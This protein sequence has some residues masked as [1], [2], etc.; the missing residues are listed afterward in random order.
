MGRVLQERNQLKTKVNELKRENTNLQKKL[1]KSVESLKPADK[2]PENLTAELQ[3]RTLCKDFWP[4]TQHCTGSFIFI[5]S[6][7]VIKFNHIGCGVGGVL[8]IMGGSSGCGL[9][10]W[11]CTG[12][13][14]T[15]A[16]VFVVI[17]FS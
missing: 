11:R 12:K 13:V 4:A 14:E 3:V 17:L 5:P 9:C 7:M 16:Y 6:C 10:P 2:P 15:Y 8:L 1:S